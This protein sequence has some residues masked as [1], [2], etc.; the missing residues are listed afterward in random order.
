MRHALQCRSLYI[1]ILCILSIQI[2][3]ACSQSSQGP[4]SGPN[5]NRAAV[6]PRS[7]PSTPTSPQMILS[8]EE[9]SYFNIWKAK[10]IKSCDPDANHLNQG[11]DQTALSKKFTLAGIIQTPND[12]YFVLG[13]PLPLSGNQ[14]SIKKWANSQNQWEFIQDGAVCEIRVNGQLIHSTMIWKSIPLIAHVNNLSSQRAPA[15]EF[16]GSTKGREKPHIIDASLFLLSA[17]TIISPND[18]SRQ[19]L[20]QFLSIKDTLIDNYIRLESPRSLPHTIVGVDSSDSRAFNLSF[21]SLALSD[22]AY[23]V[24]VRKGNFRRTFRWIFQ[25]PIEWRIATDPTTFSWTL[26]SRHLMSG[27]IE[28][29]GFTLLE[30]LSL[31]EPRAPDLQLAGQCLVDRWEQVK[32]GRMGFSYV[33]FSSPC[34]GY[35]DEPALLF[36]HEP[37]LRGIF[38]SIVGRW[39]LLS[40]TDRLQW[41]G[42]L[43]GTIQKLVG[44]SESQLRSCLD[45][46]GSTEALTRLSQ[47]IDY[48]LQREKVIPVLK[49]FR[50]SVN[51]LA[52]HWNLKKD[53]AL[54]GWKESISN[55]IEKVGGAFEDSTRELLLRLA[56][57]PANTQRSLEF[58]QGLTPSKID[59]IL[60]DRAEA[61]KAG[62]EKYYDSRLRRIFQLMPSES[63]LALW[64]K[65]GGEGT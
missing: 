9:L 37:G 5:S 55:L 12:E 49:E 43:Y 18:L 35:T 42:A 40:A 20:A 17:E 1:F 46:I 50:S 25:T 38:A 8:A 28:D 58:A 16:K 34:L 24:L 15:V 33:E 65:C 56:V 7:I 41:T 54:T 32:S 4:N 27:S 3:G 62:C 47:D 10:L 30:S 52:T 60:K 64:K 63:E 57:D 26:Q 6:T 48:F 51:L 21:T 19:S 14:H 59:Q 29:G 39:N 44:S 13:R 23:S 53:V 36:A 61:R 31:K 11:L 2:L 45:P 22:D